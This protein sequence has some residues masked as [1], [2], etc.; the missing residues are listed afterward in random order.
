MGKAD[1]VEDTAHG[2]LCSCDSFWY[3]KSNGI[4]SD[5]DPTEMGTCKHITASFKELKAKNDSNQEVFGE[6]S[7]L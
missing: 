2:Y 1:I 3:R 5:A 6:R 4:E 7:D